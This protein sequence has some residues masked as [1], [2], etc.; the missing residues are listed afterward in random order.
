MIYVGEYSHSNG[1]FMTR[2]IPFFRRTQW[3]LRIMQ[4]FLFH[5]FDFD[6]VD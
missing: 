1:L 5:T 4:H 6:I 2:F 3:K